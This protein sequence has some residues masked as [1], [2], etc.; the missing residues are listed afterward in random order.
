MTH[1]SPAPVVRAKDLARF[2]GD[3]VGVCDLTV[4]IPPGTVGLL[5]PN[6]AG[7]STFLKLLAGEL[8]PSRG[9][10]EVLGA[11]PFANPAVHSRLGFCPQQDALWDDMTALEFVEFL[12]R[13]SGFEPARARKAALVALERVQ[14]VDA[15]DR[16]L[17]G[18]S[19][20]MRQ[21]ARIAQSIAHE[22]QLVVLDEPLTGLDPLARHATLE[23]FRQLAAEGASVLFSTHVL[24][25]VEALTT[26][27][28]L[29]HRG[30]LLARG[31]VPAIR[32]LLD[33]HP[34]RY[35]IQAR[36][37]RRLARELVELEGVEAV[38]IAEGGMLVVET[39]QPE[40]LLEA[41]PAIASAA[42]AGIGAF[43]SRDEGLEAVFDYLM[44]GS[45]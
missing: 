37:P 20:G 13:L 4:D 9:S 10:I 31:E 44:G 7:K 41:L 3:V 15:K 39:R 34:R 22:P 45:T 42:R 35:S 40:R 19:K 18:F 21:R 2:Y 12:L 36:E 8:K 14:L 6:G 33:R 1:A 17:G 26:N 30:R 28:V 16:R 27:V 29:L 11:P 25:E 23:L 43:E 5:G 24:H 38:R 32:A